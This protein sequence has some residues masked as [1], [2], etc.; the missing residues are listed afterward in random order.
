MSWGSPPVHCTAIDCLLSI[1][2]SEKFRL[3][4]FF[5]EIPKRK[6]LAEKEEENKR[7]KSSTSEDGGEHLEKVLQH[8]E[9]LGM[10]RLAS[11][12]LAL[13]SLRK[14]GLLP[15]RRDDNYTQA[16]S[17]FHDDDDDDD[18]S[19]NDDISE[20]NDNDDSQKDDDFRNDDDDSRNSDV[21]SRNSFDASRSE[22]ACKNPTK[23][24]SQDSRSPF[25]SPIN[26]P[27]RRKVEV[28]SLLSD[29]DEE[30]V[31]SSGAHVGF[32]SGPFTKV[33]KRPKS[34]FVAA[35]SEFC[36]GKKNVTG[37]S[38]IPNKASTLKKKNGQLFKQGK[39][40][41]HD[42]W[43][44]NGEDRNSTGKTNSSNENITVSNSVRM[45]EGKSVFKR[46][47]PTEP[48]SVPSTE[49][50]EANP[51]VTADTKQAEQ[52]EGS[53]SEGTT[54]KTITENKT[55][56]METLRK[57]MLE[58]TRLEAERKNKGELENP[59]VGLT[60][61]FREKKGL[62]SSE[63]P[64]DVRNLKDTMSRL[65]LYRTEKTLHD[66]TGLELGIRNDDE[67]EGDIKSDNLICKKDI[68]E[69]CIEGKVK[70]EDGESDPLKES[71]GAKGSPKLAKE[72]NK[73]TT[74][75]DD[76]GNDGDDLSRS[77][78]GKI[79]DDVNNINNDDKE[80]LKRQSLRQHFFNEETEAQTVQPPIFI[81]SEVTSSAGS[82]GD[83][84]K[85][86]RTS[87]TV[88]TSN[89]VNPNTEDELVVKSIEQTG[90][91]RNDDSVGKMASNEAT[92]DP[93]SSQILAASS[94]KQKSGITP[95]GLL[96]KFQVLKAKVGKMN[97]GALSN[98]LDKREL[99]EGD[100]DKDEKEK[101]REAENKRD[102]EDSQ[103][104]YNWIESLDKNKRE[105][106]KP[107]DDSRNDVGKLEKGH[108]EAD[109]EI[110]SEVSQTKDDD[111][112]DKYLNENAYHTRKAGH[113]ILSGVSRAEDA[114]GSD[115][116]HKENAC[117][118]TKAG[119]KISSGLSK[120][121]DASGSD[122][123][124][125]ENACRPTKAGHKILSGVSQAK[126]SSG[127][128][129]YYNENA[130]QELGGG[131][132]HQ[133]DEPR[134]LGDP[135]QN[136]S[137]LTSKVAEKLKEKQQ[138]M[139]EDAVTLTVSRSSYQNNGSD[140]VCKEGDDEE[141]AKEISS[142][143]VATENMEA[144]I[145]KSSTCL[146]SQERNPE[147]FCIAPSERAKRGARKTVVKNMKGGGGKSKGGKR[148]SQD[149]SGRAK[150]NITV[151]GKT[152]V[153]HDGRGTLKKNANGIS[154]TSASNKK[155]KKLRKASFSETNTFSFID[156]LFMVEGVPKVGKK[157]KLKL[158]CFRFP[159][160]YGELC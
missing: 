133:G 36:K 102:Q 46:N 60:A 86:A 8:V 49:T 95:K 140:I 56:N 50:K 126:D 10:T 137:E 100:A 93:K 65:P 160:R 155:A 115:V 22:D 152:D 64:I 111:G 156:N 106:I 149:S 78:G 113:T 158:L 9:P 136:N 34:S 15:E 48:A 55:T 45:S 121:E 84:S 128:N 31:E 119:H 92:K 67:V 24:S 39:S 120:A 90:I 59:V 101:C 117:H 144:V 33:T 81:P 69:G 82:Q 108:T 35:G 138:G 145:D 153:D 132:A 12:E 104:K 122:L 91:E 40:L 13:F 20:N 6:L 21:D 139:N 131:E 52:N 135:N 107:R 11:K 94:D 30:E 142:T 76:N 42:K 1:E 159:C 88:S 54:S 74:D 5:Q 53:M 51:N 127:G 16:T 58:F 4:I 143:A 37:S 146:T 63:I 29:T 124:H 57:E 3:S 47:R 98:S 79:D 96:K 85:E 87:Q 43:S 2:I 73:E 25:S 38:D 61:D 28:I 26:K 148:K 129:E 23:V 19:Q 110:S 157:W 125:N 123:N 77:I 151:N 114:S 105:G 147:S 66:A 80:S 99:S 18:D 32:S 27:P 68:F 75:N 7:K 112:E 130:C 150:T 154:K 109:N 71:H 116:N 89:S 134:E 17:S 70:D 83:P 14:E 97:L 118:P 41:F 103:D 72:C 141:I 62:D 44:E